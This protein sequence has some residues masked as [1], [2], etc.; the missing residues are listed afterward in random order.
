MGC[1]LGDR[2]GS[3]GSGTVYR[4][5]QLSVGRE[6]AVKLIP[7]QGEADQRK[8]RFDREVRAIGALRNPH[9]VPI[10]DAGQEDGLLVLVM[11]LIPGRDLGAI[12]AEQGPL[13]PARAVAVVCQIANA[14]DAAHAAGVV[15]RDVKPSNILIDESS[16]TMAAY[17]TDFGV[18]RSL[19][20]DQTITSPGMFVGT[21]SYAAPEQLR[22]SPATPASDIYALAGV[23]HVGLTGVKPNQD[24][25]DLDS[26]RSLMLDP[27]SEVVG[28]GM[29]MTP[30]DR[31]SSAG[32]LA[33]AALKVLTPAVTTAS[34][35]D[36]QAPRSAESGREP[37]SPD[38]ASSRRRHRSGVVGDP[39]ILAI[40]LL[41]LALVGL[42]ASKWWYEPGSKPRS[43][44]STASTTPQ[45]SNESGTRCA[46]TQATVEYPPQWKGTCV[47]SP[48]ASRDSN[49]VVAAQWILSRRGDYEGDIDGVFG[50]LTE[51]SVIF[52]Q[53]EA[54]PDQPDAWDGVIGDDTW[55]ALADSVVVTRTEGRSIYL[56]AETDPAEREILRLIPSSDGRASWEVKA[57]TGCEDSSD[58]VSMDAQRPC[59]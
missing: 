35:N 10:H 38:A 37:D 24:G 23:L 42:G 9:V 3:G 55:Q 49:L 50:D 30:A 39:R 18:A 25:P 51:Q 15:H 46:V 53:S 32:A 2:L 16:P 4:A 12:I 47:V 48:R 26:T 34:H 6:V 45:G 29:A 22:G 5:W 52:F 28:R 14:L 8:A 11:G 58:W 41:V 19:G 57:A 59:S 1:Q 40:V 43:P 56:A 54:F 31:Y 44:S 33:A 27:L 36:L 13:S 20:G 17:L 21:P 7:S